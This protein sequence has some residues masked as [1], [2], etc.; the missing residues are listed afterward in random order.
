MQYE[1]NVLI[2]DTSH[3]HGGSPPFANI[4]NIALNIAVLA[5]Q[6]LQDLHGKLCECYG[7]HHEK[8]LAKSCGDLPSTRSCG[9]I[10]GCAS[11]CHS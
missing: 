11:G 7:L 4:A 5:R 1:S 9:C 8:L 6:F 10:A 3:V 2:F